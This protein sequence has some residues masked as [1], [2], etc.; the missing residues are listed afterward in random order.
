MKNI[1]TLLL[2]LE[3]QQ[4]YFYAQRL[5]FVPPADMHKVCSDMNG[6]TTFE[7]LRGCS[8]LSLSPYQYLIICA[9]LGIQSAEHCSW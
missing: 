9:H 2:M 4:S 6:V 8:D 5:H 1:A 3:L 7:I